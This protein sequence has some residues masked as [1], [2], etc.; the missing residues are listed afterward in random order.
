MI[1]YLTRDIERALG[2]P[3]LPDFFII[4]NATPFAKQI[5]AG[6]DN[7]FLVN[8][9]RLLDT[10]E[11]LECTAVRQ[12]ISNLTKDPHI[13]VF[14][15]TS[16]IEQTCKTQG[17][18]LLNPPAA[19]ADMVEQKISQVDWLGDLQKYLPLHSIAVSEEVSWDSEPFIL[20]FNRA[21]TGSGTVYI[22]TETQ[23]RQVQ[24]QF[25]H[26][27][28]RVTKYISGPMLTN[29]NIVTSD[30]V[31][32]GTIN[33]QIT[34]LAP[35][36]DNRFAT[37]GNDWGVVSQLLTDAQRAA[38]VEIATAVGEKLRH[39]G[40]RGA[41][42]IDVALETASGKLYL[43]EVNA[44]QPASLTYE[45]Y[46]Q[47]FSPGCFLQNVKQ[48]NAFE[49]HIT[50]LLEQDIQQKYSIGV[51]DGAQII[52]RQPMN[53]QTWELETL[54]KIASRLRKLG[55][56]LVLYT[57][58]KPGSDAL[59]IQSLQSIMESHNSFNDVGKNIL[60]CI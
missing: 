15:N 26:R 20:Q 28:V 57:N 41:F 55:L 36:T 51:Q 18:E 52:L 49:L 50:A 34:G 22:E 7:V 53:G 6:Y 30:H 42:G 33:Y 11:L 35:F 47:Q 45:S 8:E 59:R 39:D 14:K 12:H 48:L 9:G 40:W 17:W 29:N 13:V 44:R 54:E 16:L 60:A 24:Q 21:H 25:P 58:T 10:R 23:L 43:I 38:Y 37:I 2:A 1:F 56:K 3:R 4:S 5:A 27:P 32:V 31:I 19:V 46:L